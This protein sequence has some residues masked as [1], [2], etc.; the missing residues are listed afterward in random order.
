MKDLDLA[1]LVAVFQEMLGWAFWAIVAVSALATLVFVYVLLRD[2][3][4]VPA[5]L[6]RAEALGVLGGGAAVVAMFAVTNSSVSDLGG[7]IDWLLALGIFLVGLFGTAVGAYALMGLFAAV[8]A[9][10][11]RAASGSRRAA[12]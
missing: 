8:P 4:I 1:T 6:V 9:P 3:G 5:R 7:P 12:A 2:R 10:A 11:P